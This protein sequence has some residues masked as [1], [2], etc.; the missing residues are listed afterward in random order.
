MRG[1]EQCYGRGKNKKKQQ[2]LIAIERD[3]DCEFCASGEN[4]W[5]FLDAAILISL[6]DR[7]DRT[8]IGIKEFHKC[9][10]CQ[11]GYLYL[12]ERD[13]RGFVFGCWDSTSQVCKLSLQ[14]G[15]EVIGSFEDDFVFDSMR[16]IREIAKSIH[17]AMLTLPSNWQ[18]LSLG[19]QSYIKFRYSKL[20][21][22]AT[23][24]LTH[25]QIWSRS[26]MKWMSE[27]NV[28]KY[29]YIFNT[30]SLEQV[31]QMISYKCLANY[32][33]NPM[34]AYQKNLSSDRNNMEYMVQ[35]PFTDA[36]E[37]LYPFF[38]FLGAIILIVLITLICYFSGL[39]LGS[40]LLFSVAI[41]GIPFLT[42]WILALTNQ[43]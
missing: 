26:G 21:D 2:M 12:A 25:A 27:N 17:E 29:L 42:V 3:A 35:Q 8:L 5:S 32:A 36:T 23:S 6:K 20:I 1:R 30:Y 14:E 38:W 15:F 19:Q 37:Y 11:I 24:T 34:V 16:E 18:R 28:D 10:L 39:Y 43:I 22:R 9:G 13:K 33:M 4:I 31:D 7:K 41:V 40:S